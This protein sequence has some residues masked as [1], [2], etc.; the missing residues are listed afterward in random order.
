MDESHALSQ[1]NH[2]PEGSYWHGIL[3]RRE[4]DWSNARYWFRAVGA[5]PLFAELAKPPAGSAGDQEAPAFSRVARAGSWDPLAF[6]TL[7]EACEQGKRAELRAELEALQE[8][9]IHL[10]LAHSYTGAVGAAHGRS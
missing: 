3:H 5:H 6:I 1:E 7:C 2:T 8:R 9:E 4:P 10:L